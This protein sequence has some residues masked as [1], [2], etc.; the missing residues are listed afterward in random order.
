MNRTTFRVLLTLAPVLMWTGAS[1]AAG[2]RDDFKPVPKKKG[3]V[4]MAFAHP[5]G[6]IPTPKEA[7]FLNRVR[8]QLEPQLRNALDRV[9]NSSDKSERLKAVKEVKQIK[10]QY[11]A[12]VYSVLQTRYQEAMRKE[13]ERRKALAKKRAE[14]RKKHNHKNRHKK[15]RR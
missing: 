3:P 7:E 10:Y 11:R 8:S 12:A 6:L 9:Q 13:M 15:K 2:D 5:P 1:L 4:E 14:Q